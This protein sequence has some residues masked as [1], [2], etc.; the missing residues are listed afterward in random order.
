MT[1]AS[2]TPS[3]GALLT[4]PLVR[5]LLVVLAGFLLGGLTS[6]AQGFL[7]EAFSSFAN[8]SSGWTILTVAL[9][10]WSRLRTGPAA[11]LGTATFVVLLLGYSVA[12][13]LRGYY[14]DPTTW[15]VIGIVVGPF[16]GVAAAWLRGTGLGA[17]L[18]AGV[19]AGVGLGEAVYGLTV[20]HETTSPVYWSVLGVAALALLV[21]MLVRRVRGPLPAAVAVVTALVVTAGVPVGYASLG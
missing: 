18:A 14:Y 8:S 11:A 4:R 13:Q 17:A 15:L 19:L 3:A 9:V 10:F 21:G 6:Y 1:T 5:A 7:P 20:V 12:A 16:V 2:R